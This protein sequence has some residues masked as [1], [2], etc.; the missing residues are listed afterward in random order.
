MPLKKG[1][2]KSVIKLNIRELVRAGRT[3]EQ[4]VAIALRNAGRARKRKR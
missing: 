3:R 2:G 1:K 4:A